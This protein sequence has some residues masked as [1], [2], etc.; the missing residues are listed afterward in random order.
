VAAG[1]AWGLAVL[2]GV[3]VSCALSNTG[4][5]INFVIPQMSPFFSLL[6]KLES[7]V[8]NRVHPHM[9]TTPWLSVLFLFGSRAN[10]PFFFLHEP[11]YHC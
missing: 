1:W 9:E 8:T 5:M 6:Y 11:R 10:S 7:Y 3:R 4:L 2:M